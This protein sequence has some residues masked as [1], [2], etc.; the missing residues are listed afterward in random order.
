MKEYRVAFTNAELEYPSVTLPLG[1]LDWN[2]RPFGLVAAAAE[3]QEE[4]LIDVARAW[5][6]AFPARRPPNMVG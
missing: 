1:Y 3:F 5:E 2:G 4:L 6:S